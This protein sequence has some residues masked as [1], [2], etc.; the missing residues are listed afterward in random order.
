MRGQAAGYALLDEVLDARAC[1][2]EAHRALERADMALMRLAATVERMTVA[3]RAE[4]R[5]A[6]GR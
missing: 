1:Q 5:Q 2:I 6:R 4:R 3:E